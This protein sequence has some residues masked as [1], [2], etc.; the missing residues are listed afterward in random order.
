MKV[1]FLD[2]LTVV[3]LRV[4]QSKETFLEERARFRVSGYSVENDWRQTYSSSFQN[5]KAMFWRPWVS[6]TPAIPS[7]PHRKA[8]D[9]ASS[10]VKSVVSQYISMRSKIFNH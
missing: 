8:R 9:R 10:W 2:T 6:D 5:A 7:S 3:T 1:G 4:G